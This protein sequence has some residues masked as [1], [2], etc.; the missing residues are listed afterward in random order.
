MWRNLLIIV[1]SIILVFSYYY[2]RQ[3]QFMYFPDTRSPTLAD[4]NANNFTEVKLRTSDNL[5]LLAWYKKAKTGQPTLLYLHGNAGHIGYR[6]PILRPYLDAGLGVLLLSYRGYG[7]NQGQPTETGLYR[8]GQA[9][10]DFLQKTQ[11]IPPQCIVLFGESLGTGVAVELA[12]RQRV[13]AVIM[14]AAYSSMV[15][16]AARHFPF[17]PSDWLLKDRFD[18]ASKIHQLQTPLLFIHGER[19][20]IVPISLAEK[21]FHRAPEP[22]VFHRYPERG[23]ND[24]FHQTMANDV[25]RFVGQSV[26]CAP[27][28]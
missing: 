10:L 28:R 11:S 17:L 18:S 13:G 5:S 27:L 1:V 8:D 21:L 12:S 20:H 7:G 23:H 16:M 4:W 2:L 19:D 9:A 22:K 6:I 14:Q 25:L 24:L 26:H 15:D 3:R